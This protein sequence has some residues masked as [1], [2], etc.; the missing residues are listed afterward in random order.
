[1]DQSSVAI[2]AISGS[3]EDARHSIEF[4]AEGAIGS[5]NHNHNLRTNLSLQRPS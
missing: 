3:L 2:D 5:L 4:V 1:M